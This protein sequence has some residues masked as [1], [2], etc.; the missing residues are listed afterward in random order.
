MNVFGDIRS[1]LA[2][3]PS[4]EAWQKLIEL[5]QKTAPDEQREVYLPYIKSHLDKNNWP[6][7]LRKLHPD[8]TEESLQGAKNK[9]WLQL[10]S[11][12]HLTY[13]DY[14]D[15][16]PALDSDNITKLT[17]LSF[18][19]SG[20]SINETLHRLIMHNKVELQSLILPEDALTEVPETLWHNPRLASLREFKYRSGNVTESFFDNIFIKAPFFKNLRHL[21]LE[22]S[23]HFDHF[24][25]KLEAALEPNQLESLGAGLCRLNANAMEV[26]AGSAKFANL[27]YL[28]AWNNNIGDEGIIALSQSPYIKQLRYLNIGGNIVSDAAYKAMTAS[29]NFQHLELLWIWSSTV[30]SNTLKDFFAN[31]NMPSLKKL[32]LNNNK[33]STRN[34]LQLADSPIAPNLEELHLYGTNLTDRH[35]EHLLRRDSLQSLQYLDVSS[36]QLTDEGLEMLAEASCLTSLQHLQLNSNT[37]TLRGID[38][39]AQSPHLHALK[40]VECSNE[41][42]LREKAYWPENFY[43]SH[44]EEDFHSDDVIYNIFGDVQWM[45]HDIYQ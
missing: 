18:E 5:L 30:K 9:P 32:N 6:A 44:S 4:P 33:V 25:Q 12:M 17:H 3:E 34:L 15:L 43:Q 38:A 42:Y 39:L 11:A 29:D 31:A 19:E 41:H 13:D 40:H 10:I 45:K 28:S 23:C 37:Y 21:N 2:Q 26:M 22:S 8:S 14:D 1:I 16:W 20:S 36:N 7:A 35:I 24:I 27:S